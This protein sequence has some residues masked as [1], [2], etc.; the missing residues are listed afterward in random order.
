MRTS[1]ALD[2]GLDRT[3][4]KDK[5]DALRQHATVDEILRRM[6]HPS[7]GHR[8]ELQILADEVGMGKT[9][10]ALGA[11]Y[12]I[13]EAMR[14][15]E[16]PP[17]LVGAHQKILIIT[18][19]NGSLF[20]KWYKEVKEF[21]RRCV[22]ARSRDEAGR[23]FTPVR[24][25]R[26]DEVV[27]ALRKPGPVPQVVIT[28]MT[29]FGTD[30]FQAY[31]V[32]RR[33]LMGAL[34]RYWGNAFPVEARERMLLG[35]PA[36]W[37]ADPYHLSP[38]AQEEADWLPC[39]EDE[40][41]EA[42]RKLDRPDEEG[43]ASNVERLRLVCRELGEPYARDREGRFGEV[44]R[45]LNWLYRD[46]TLVT[47]QKAIPLVVVDEAHN[48]KNGPD[49]GANGFEYFEKYVAPRTRRILLLTATPFQ[50]RPSEMLALIRIGEVCQ[51]APERGGSS[52]RKAALVARRKELETIIEASAGSSR[53]LAAAWT[54]LRSVEARDLGR[55]W[56]SKEM[57][58]ARKRLAE[59]TRSRGAAPA[60]EIR[61]VARSAVRN[62]HPGT[63]SFFD[64]ALVHYAHQVDLTAELAPLVIRH[65]R[66][67]DHRAIKVGHEYGLPTAEVALR[68]DRNVLHAAAGVDVRGDGALPHYVLMRC[69]TE[70]KGGK[71]RSALGSSLT[72]C[73]ST[74]FESSEGSKVRSRLG[75]TA[76]GKRYL[77]LL[78]KLVNKDRDES[79]PKLSLVA[80]EVIARWHAGEK[81]LVFCFRVN[82]AER[83][84]DI[85]DDRV[86][87]EL[88]ERRG[89]CLGSAE[90]L[91]N[92]RQRL[93]TRDREL[94]PIMLDRVLWSVTL[95]PPDALG[96]VPWRPRDLAVRDDDLRELARTILAFAQD[97]M[98][99]RP[100]RVFLDRAVHHA[101]ARRLLRTAK[102]GPKWRAVLEQIADDGWVARPYGVGHRAEVEGGEDVGLDERGVHHAF[103]LGSIE[104]TSE[105]VDALASRLRLRRERARGGSLIDVASEGPSL[106]FG[107]PP[108]VIARKP[109]A[110]VRTIHDHLSALT[111]E[112]GQVDWRGRLLVMQALRRAVL[113]ESVLA[114]VLPEKVDRGDDGWG[115][116]VVRSMFGRLTGQSESMAD[117]IAIYLEDLRGA[118]GT[119]AAPDDPRGALLAASR[120]RE[121]RFVALVKGGDQAARERI[122]TGFN[123]PLL[124]EILVCT[125]VGAEGIDLHRHCRHV[126][127]YDLAWNPAVLE[128]RT[129]RVDRIGSKTFRERSGP[130]GSG[131][132]LEVGVPFLAGTYDERMYEEL[133][134][135]AQQFEVLTGGDLSAD[136]VDGGDEHEGSEGRPVGLQ[137]VPL[138]PAMLDDLRVKLHV[139]SAAK[140][141]S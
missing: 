2:L 38:S 20:R 61:D 103:S 101:L 19:P 109:A 59:L 120:L 126:V 25:E 67:T 135:R 60:Q 124:P 3:R 65:R 52:D 127:H 119:L 86:R 42:L 21:V 90:K 6:F 87:R 8:Q 74:L 13:L 132:Y 75:A 50:L 141:D 118:G 83:L 18:P 45:A 113:R 79:H 73:W 116:L 137:L 53:R 32:K 33:F 136:G 49:A 130:N 114:R 102:P 78:E 66:K 107:G 15:G 115:E 12:S 98:G 44:E 97:V 123:T 72:G 131:T 139:W 46:V 48:W 122:F 91:A 57:I 70:S 23:W 28:K 138:P 112:H 85:I 68:S 4:I 77:S 95:S 93:T 26:L 55:T 47:L 106:W 133:R 62:L 89:R 34:F 24:A 9:F 76:R 40:A 121:Q 104:P 84:R 111:F 69:V 29:A 99:E 16:I 56:A 58:T 128:Q 129:G 134:L 140:R 108:E 43:G 22:P 64:A 63:R 54:K 27:R 51:L 125:S 88:H 14:R 94:I 105:D 71:G 80:D 82:T 35:A 117:R 96:P 92:L 17:D 11:A 7:A 100:D 10:V 30:K 81:S 41:V 1:K 110:T 37:P 31:D 39:T 36:G 5:N